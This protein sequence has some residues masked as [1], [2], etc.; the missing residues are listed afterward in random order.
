MKL[1]KHKIKFKT[2]NELV[3][4]C[5]AYESLIEEYEGKD[6]HSNLLREHAIE[7]AYTFIQMW[8]NGKKTVSISGVSALA[9]CQLWG[10]ALDYIA[11]ESLSYV[12][13]M[14]IRDEIIQ[15]SVSK[16]RIS[17]RVLKHTAQYFNNI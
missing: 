13:V 14:R 16:N 17:E 9:F 11:K 6:M 12:Q 7:Q 15:S 8:M 3:A 4:V 1:P 2:D 5:R 10:A